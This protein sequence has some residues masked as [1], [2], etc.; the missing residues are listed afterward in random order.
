MGKWS[1]DI[2]IPKQKA[3]IRK[4]RPKSRPQKHLIIVKFQSELI[5]GKHNR[6][7]GIKNKEL[8]IWNSEVA[9]MVT[10]ANSK[11]FKS[12]LYSKTVNDFI[13]DRH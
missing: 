5:I 4:P 12:G 6:D 3:A 2:A 10:K 7:A 9:M 8:E 11:I 13:H 1:L